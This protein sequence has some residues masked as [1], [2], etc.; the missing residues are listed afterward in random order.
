MK[1]VSSSDLHG[2]LQ[3]RID[4]LLQDYRLD[5]SRHIDRIIE[6]TNG[7]SES[8][9]LL[10]QEVVV[11]GELT[12]PGAASK[13]SSQLKTIVAELKFPEKL[14]HAS[15]QNLLESLEELLKKSTTAGR[16]YIP[17]LP[18]IHKKVIKELDFHIRVVSQEYQKI[19]KIFDKNKLPQQLDT[20]TESVIDLGQK[21]EQLAIILDKLA[22]LQNQQSA[23]VEKIEEQEEGIEQFRVE[24]G[25]AEIEAI[26]REID[27]IRM[28]VTNQLNFLKK[29]LRKLSQS[30]GGTLM[31]SSTAIEGANAYSAD[32][33]RA[34]Q[35]D[36][37]NLEKLKASLSALSNAVQAGKIKFKQ[38][39]DRK[40]L[41]RKA[42]I[43]DKAA[44]DELRARFS[45][46]NARREELVSGVSTD[47]RR[48]LEK[49]LER[50]Q[51]EHR[52]IKAEIT[53]SEEKMKRATESI[54]SL[55][56]KI[57][58]SLKHHLNDEVQIE[59]PEKIQVHLDKTG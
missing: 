47:E 44:I 28:L 27:A 39:I 30:A 24:S 29:P 22:E 41:E 45:I 33:W 13:L 55:K 46:L 18:K 9:D 36:A 15:V 26:R 42:E 14:T 8:S 54:K 35:E 31:I 40:I 23:T 3:E 20:L 1:T 6:A 58:Q 12:I 34:F 10:L 19:K 49:T 5:L 11:D 56:K 52:D 50:A 43:C 38:S 51:W 16:R 25:L 7:I 37:E 48:E 59:L 17:R 32:S 53:H 21:T 4:D 2:W 57:E